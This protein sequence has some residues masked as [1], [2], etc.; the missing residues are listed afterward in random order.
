MWAK[1]TLPLTLKCAQKGRV[2]AAELN[3]SMTLNFWKALSLKKKMQRLSSGVSGISFES[4]F[5]FFPQK[6]KTKNPE[7]FLQCMANCKSRG[8]QASRERVKGQRKARSV[9]FWNYFQI[10]TLFFGSFS[11]WIIVKELGLG[12][13]WLQQFISFFILFTERSLVYHTEGQF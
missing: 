8:G 9:F 13:K 4:F 6:G 12:R 5:F 1:Y 7:S 2:R 10:Q 11:S 3:M